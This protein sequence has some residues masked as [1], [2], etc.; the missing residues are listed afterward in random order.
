MAIANMPSLSV[1]TLNAS[2][3]INFVT[4]SISAS[5][6]STELMPSNYSIFSCRYETMLCFHDTYHNNEHLWQSNILFLSALNVSIMYYPQ[7]VFHA[8]LAISDSSLLL[9]VCKDIS[10]L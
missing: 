5:S 7:R 10:R 2:A 8:S 6:H 1:S 3:E 4:S 9:N